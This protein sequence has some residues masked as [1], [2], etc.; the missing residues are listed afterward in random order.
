MRIVI[1]RHGESEHNKIEKDVKIFC[2]AIDINLT[3]EGKQ[4]AIYLQDNE[5]IKSIE[6]IYSSDLIRAYD[7]AR[8][9]TEKL[10]LEIKVDTRLRERSL[11]K[12]DGR[13]QDEVEKEYPEY[14]KSPDLKF[15]RDFVEKAPDGENYTDVSLRLKSFLEDLN[16][17]EISTIGIFSHMHAIRCLLYVL[18]G[19]T[20]D[21][22]LKL[23]I[24]NSDPIVVEGNKIGEFKLLS[25]KLEDMLSYGK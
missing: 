7:T 14:F 6:R 12:F 4:S 24:V 23:K 3:E 11:G 19:L 1:V 20:K 25:H 17:N 18:L 10:G 15:R 13:Y 2:G 21:E 22:I 16:L 5:Y 9:S 8:L